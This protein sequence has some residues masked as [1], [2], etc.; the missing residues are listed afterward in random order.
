MRSDPANVPW[1]WRAH[2]AM[3]ARPRSSSAASPSTGAARVER[4][5]EAGSAEPHVLAVEHASRL[6]ARD[7][8]HERRLVAAEE[9]R[10]TEADDVRAGLPGR[11]H[12]VAQRAGGLDLTGRE[13]V[14]DADLLDRD[15]E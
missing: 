14:A 6:V 11:E 12:G 10:G 13:V 9:L 5:L 8:A 15:D 3:R 4:R 2:G 1:P 7:H